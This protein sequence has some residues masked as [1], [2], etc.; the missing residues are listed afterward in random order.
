MDPAETVK[1]WNLLCAA[2]GDLYRRRSRSTVVTLCLAAILFPFVTALAVSEGVRFQAELSVREGADI[3]VSESQSEATDSVDLGLREKLALLP[4]VSRVAPRVVGRTYVVDRVVAVVGV[5]RDSLGLLGPIVRGR[6]PDAPGEVLIG[7]GVSKKFGIQTGV[8]FT[9]PA[10]NRKVFKASGVLA[11]SC[12]WGSDIIVTHYDDANEFFRTKGKVTHLLVYTSSEIEPVAAAIRE[13]RA[14]K[15]HDG[16]GQLRVEGRGTSLAKL[17]SAY[18]WSQGIF[19][20][21]LM[22]GAALTIQAFVVTSGSGQAELRR[23]MGVM[24][25]IGWKTVDLLERVA[26]ENLAISVAAVCLSILLSLAWMKGLNGIFLAQFYV[27]EVG[28]VPEI[29]IP[30]R[31]IP[32]HLL[33]ALAFALAITQLGGLFSVWRSGRFSPK[34]S[35]R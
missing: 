34:E 29:E 9:L 20:V 14:N 25:A 18:T 4:G 15:E 11:P 13:H 16:S 33:F 27:A 5:E 24:R 22:V 8:P 7:H 30:F 1:H 17:R 21:L 12:L 3:Y 19:A 28:V 6:V 31:A 23:E 26:F 2:L 35:M 32:S 10:N